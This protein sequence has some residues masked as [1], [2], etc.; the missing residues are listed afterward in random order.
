ME[1]R[2]KGRRYGRDALLTESNVLSALRIAAAPAL[3]YAIATTEKVGLLVLSAHLA[4]WSTDLVD[5]WLSRRHGSTKL[6]DGLDEKS[7]KVLTW[8]EFAG[9]MVRGVYGF[10]GAGMLGIMASR[11]ILITKFRKKLK[12]DGM[13]TSD[14][15]P[16]KI[17]TNLQIAAIGVPLFPALADNPALI[18]GSLAVATVASVGSGL[19]YV[20]EGRK[21]QR[22]KQK[23]VQINQT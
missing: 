4:L 10:V 1:R 16:G 5:G 3:G 23:D 18:K 9:L 14:K 6:G 12:K 20:Y 11:D 13:N 17:K 15:L 7:D 2:G 8:A 22:K 21:Q 19:H